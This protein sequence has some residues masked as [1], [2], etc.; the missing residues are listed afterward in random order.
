MNEKSHTQWTELSDNALLKTIGSFIQTHRLNQNKSQ[1]AVA[2]TANI[3][4]STL[5][6][7]ERGK[8]V[9]MDSFIRVLRVL[10]LLHVMDAFTIQDEISPL[11]YAK[12]KKKK[13]KQASPIKP[14]ITNNQNDDLGW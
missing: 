3:S 10:D 5:S 7:I 1:E 12:L 13:R 2:T 9:R 14:A 6:L 11:V 8:I 4:R